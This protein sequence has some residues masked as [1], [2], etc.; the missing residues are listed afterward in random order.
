MLFS[1]A[2]NNYYLLFFDAELSLEDVVVRRCDGD[3]VVIS[4]QGGDV[5]G[6]IGTINL[7]GYHY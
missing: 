2:F 5:D 6:V 1:Y 7:S 4:S 3:D